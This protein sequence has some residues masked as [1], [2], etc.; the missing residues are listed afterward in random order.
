VHVEKLLES[1]VGKIDAKLFEAVE[2][3]NFET[4]DIQDTDELVSGLNSE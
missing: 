2:L 3:E 1:F 4:G